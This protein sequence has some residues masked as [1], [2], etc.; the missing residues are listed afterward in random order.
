M[1]KNEKIV[2]FRRVRGRV[3]P[4]SG[5]VAGNAGLAAVALGGMATLQGRNA[6]KEL[7]VARWSAKTAVKLRKSTFETYSTL[8]DM[9]MARMISSTDFLKGRNQL[10]EMLARGHE[11]KTA[12]RALTSRLA[13]EIRLAKRLGKVAAGFGVVALGALAYQKLSKKKK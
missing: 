1:K 11:I 8:K 5:H 2:G 10:H 3:I 7:K 12:R 4:I 13:S 9:R 6:A